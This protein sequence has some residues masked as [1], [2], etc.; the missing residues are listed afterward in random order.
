[1]T[2]DDATRA[3]L[4]AAIPS[5]RAFAYSLCGNP[6]TSDDLVQEALLKAW[7][8]LTSF[9]PG[10]SMTA[11]LFTILRNVFFSTYRKRRREVEDPDEAQALRM[12]SPP[13]QVAHVAFGEFAKAL[14]ALAPHQR[15][16]L[17]LVEVLGFSFQEAAAVIG[18]PVNTAKSRTIRARASLVAA[19]A[20][21]GDK[22]AVLE[23]AF[24]N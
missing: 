15:E 8:N 1:M 9:Q 14:A 10:T 7:M 24:Y 23:P 3:E 2:H 17:Y 5:L 16:A 12:T 20:P 6:D 11:W 13:T 21:D 4:L 22:Q 18:T 19:L